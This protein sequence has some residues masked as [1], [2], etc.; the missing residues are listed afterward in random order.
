MPTYRMEAMG[1]L[2]MNHIV[3]DLYDNSVLNQTLEDM[4]YVFIVKPHPRTPR[5][6]LGPRNNF[7]VLSYYDI[8][9]NQELMAVGDIMVTDYSSCCIDFALLERP[10]I[11]YR[12]DEEQFFKYSEKVCDEYFY[13]SNKN[14]ARTPEELCKLIETPSLAS[15]SAIDDLY[16]D[17]SIKGTC[18]CENVFH[19]ICKQ[20]GIEQSVN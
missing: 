14:S 20:I 2:E 10:V 3:Q 4:N 8:D 17:S 7:K 12:P 19:V 5:I 1:K 6:E 11:F 15:T 9:S 16:E 13:F 18:Y